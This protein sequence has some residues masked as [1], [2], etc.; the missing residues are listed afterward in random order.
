MSTWESRLS[1]R[2][3]KSVSVHNKQQNSKPP[4]AKAREITFTV[5]DTMDPVGG[6]ILYKAQ[7]CPAFLY[8][9]THQVSFNLERL[10]IKSRLASDPVNLTDWPSE[11]DSEAREAA[12]TCG[13]SAHAVGHMT[14]VCNET[15]E[16]AKL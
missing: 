12:R 16:E 13:G 14:V 1:Q 9:L 2:R 8:F 11:S 5:F 6:D 10:N 15:A 4:Y 7:S 3:C